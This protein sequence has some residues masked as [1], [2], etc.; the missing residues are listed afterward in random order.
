MYDS[1]DYLISKTIDGV[2]IE[3]FKGFNKPIEYLP[4]NVKIILLNNE[5]NQPIDYL[6]NQVEQIH[7][8]SDYN[9]PINNLPN[10]L[11]FVYF[12]AHFNQ[13][14]DN[15]PDSVE[16]IR[17]SQFYNCKINKLP[18]SLK[19]FNVLQLT[20][21]FIDFVEDTIIEN[22]QQI[23]NYYEIY[24]DLELKYPNVKFIY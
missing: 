6:P 14:I 8:G 4:E 24:S 1:K 17:I 18:K 23:D 22:N 7:F 21:K 13:Q 15:L 2:E 16:E 19:V 3:F 9:H 5:Y 10:G 11:K 12:G 20:Q